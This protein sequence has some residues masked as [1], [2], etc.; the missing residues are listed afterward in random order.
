M[1]IDPQTTDKEESRNT[2][3]AGTSE[4]SDGAEENLH[5]YFQVALEVMR[6]AEKHRN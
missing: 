1:T 2:N 4:A 3:P 5:R 6:E